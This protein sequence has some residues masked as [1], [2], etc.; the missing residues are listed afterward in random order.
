MTSRNR[1]SIK[2]VAATAQVSLGTVSNFLNNPE[3]V[4]PSTASRILVAI[5]SLGYVRND[6]ARQ[7]KAGRSFIIG[8]IVPDT[9]NPFYSE[10][11]RGAEDSSSLHAYSLISGNSAN[12]S[13]REIDYLKLF[14]QQSVGGILIS[15]NG[16]VLDNLKN[17]RVHGI[18]AVLVDHKVKR[19]DACSV[20]VD[21]ISGGLLAT[22]HLL[23]RGARKVLFVGGSQSITQVRSR[24][25]GALEALK[26]FEGSE[27]EIVESKD[28]TVLSGRAVGNDIIKRPKAS[29]PDAIFAAND[30]IALGILQS[31]ILDNRVRVPQDISIIGYD[32][33]PFAESALVPLTSIRQPSYE[34]GKVSLELLLDEISNPHHKHKQVTF[35]PELIIRESA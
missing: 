35:K 6:V 5:E 19:G 8:M 7:L 28:M 23:E 1:P 34:L 32:D 27:I 2:D 14:E 17:L 15:P 26:N 30:L 29:R 24:L 3:V 12:Q 22:K 21:D 9:S 18:K 20:S 4:K 25:T 31:F 16:D 11:I 10:I 33:I 13:I